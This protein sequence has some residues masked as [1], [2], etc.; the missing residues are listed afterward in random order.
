MR[1]SNIPK[2]LEVLS[3]GF[4]SRLKSLNPQDLNEHW[5][6]LWDQLANHFAMTTV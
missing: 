2:G 5:V 6:N 4:R 1:N 3:V